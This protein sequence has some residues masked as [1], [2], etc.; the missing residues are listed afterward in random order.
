M[1]KIK[2]LIIQCLITGLIFTIVCSCV[3]RTDI[4]EIVIISNNLFVNIFERVIRLF[5]DLLH[6][7]KRMDVP[8]V[9]VVEFLIFLAYDGKLEANS[10]IEKELFASAIDQLKEQFSFN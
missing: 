5:F 4:I 2:S 7:I 6:G 1:S 8:L 3:N 9:M 10:D